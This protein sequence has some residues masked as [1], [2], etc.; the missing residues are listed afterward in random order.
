MP[1]KSQRHFRI[2]ELLN[3]EDITSQSQLADILRKEGFN[4]TQATVCR[5]L[6]ELR[7]TKLR[8]KE[9]KIKYVLPEGISFNAPNY[10]EQLR[11]VLNEWVGQYLYS[12]NLAI[13]KTSP[14]SAHVVASA[15]DRYELETCLATVAG[16]DTVLLVA[17][18]GLS[19]LDVIEEI[20][21]IINSS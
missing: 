5:D 6:E 18:E 3:Q 2:V 20:S 11:R 19:G 1:S 16:D 13:L 21:K 8:L 10:E 7:A 14:G 17:L 15:I 9:G 12:G 4:V